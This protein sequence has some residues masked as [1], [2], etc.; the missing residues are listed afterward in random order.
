MET[1][2]ENYKQCN[3]CLELKTFVEF[4]PKKGG[5]FG[6]RG[7]CR[8]CHA[9]QRHVYHVMNIKEITAKRRA[10][11]HANREIG[12]AKTK[13]WVEANRARRDAYKKTYAVANKESLAAKKQAYREANRETLAAKERA[14]HRKNP[15]VTSTRQR[16]NYLKHK[17]ARLAWCKVY[18][19]TPRG[20]AVTK[21]HGQKYRRRVQF[22]FDQLATSADFLPW[23]K[24]G[25]TCYLTGESLRPETLTLDHVVPLHWGGTHDIWNLAPA[26]RVANSIKTNR[27]VYFDIMTREPRYTLDPCPGGETWPR[28]PLTQPTMDEMQAMV[29]AW[30]AL[31]IQLAA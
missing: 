4:S 1:Q 3:E 20:K 12:I 6:L 27:L 10:Y 11:Y 14:R 25:A 29:D 31:R 9:K 5:K 28:I 21:A 17:A 16:A 15:E 7:Q 22:A 30:K 8:I 23:M 13:A 2:K 18:S 26:S 24:D 19:K